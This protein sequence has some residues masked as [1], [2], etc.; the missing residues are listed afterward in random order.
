MPEE[1]K[2]ILD[3][4]NK[5]ESVKLQVTN[6]LKET[7]RMAGEFK[8]NAVVLEDT[9]LTKILNDFIPNLD[10]FNKELAEYLSK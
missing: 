9:K 10:K 2:E 3:K 6:T 7:T 4:I 1:K 5:E 8:I